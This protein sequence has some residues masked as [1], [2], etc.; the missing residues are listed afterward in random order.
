MI[1]EDQSDN[2]FISSEFGNDAASSDGKNRWM[3]VNLAAT[4]YVTEGRTGDDA[5]ENRALQSYPNS[6]LTYFTPLWCY[7]G[8]GDG[9]DATIYNTNSRVGLFYNW[10]AATNCKGSYAPDGT[11]LDQPAGPGMANIN[12]GE[13][14]PTPQTTR[15]QGI[16]PNGWHLP[17]DREWT[18][19]EIELDRNTHQY[20]ILPD[21]NDGV[22][23]GGYSRGT[24]HG[25]AMQ[26]MCPAPGQTTWPNAYGKSNP[27]SPGVAGGFNII[28]T[29]IANSGSSFGYG[30]SAFFW[31]ASGDDSA[32]A[33][34]RDFNQT[35]S[36]VSRYSSHRPYLFS[37]RCKKD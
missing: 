24:T 4:K 16:C 2:L 17:S 6:M 9:T 13:D 29:G 21:A 32:G 23:G 11:Q 12:D 18:D 8:N 5:Q 1:T 37:V 3:I 20:S 14:E 26:D 7:P 10:A 27:V 30:G 19:L 35:T 22:I 15:I 28:L 31:T 33:W 34:F 36:T 25:Q